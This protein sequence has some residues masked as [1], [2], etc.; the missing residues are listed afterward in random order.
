[1]N[2]KVLNIVAVNGSPHNEFG[3]TAQIITMLREHLEAGGAKFKEILLSEQRIEY[4]TGCALCIQKGGCWIRDDH[5]SI[6][7][8]LL[9]ADGIIL[10]SPVYFFHVTAQMKTFVDRCLG[11]THRP[12]NS[13]KPGLTVSVSAGSGETETAAYLGHVMRSF[14]AFSIGSLTGIAL[15]AGAFLG[16]EHI[17]N[18]AEDLVIELLRAIR[19]KKRYPATDKDLAFYQFIGGLARDNPVL[20]KADHDHWKAQGLFQNFETYIGQPRS[21]GNI[22]REKLKTWLKCQMDSLRD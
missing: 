3:N 1:M 10:A 9:A 8:E 7:K 14:G 12:L 5:K 4:C 15:D 13:W 19:T 22:D 2:D 17:T 21:A 16:I 11:Y 18:R 6:V 20:L